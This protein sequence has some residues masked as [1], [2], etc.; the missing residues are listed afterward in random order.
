VPVKWKE[1]RAFMKRELLSSAKVMEI[2]SDQNAPHPS[3][4]PR[5]GERI[6]VRG[7][8]PEGEGFHYLCKDQ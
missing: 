3:L 1:K 8:F 2:L 7:E 5:R 6:K 4:S